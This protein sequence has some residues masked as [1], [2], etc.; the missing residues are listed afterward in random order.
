MNSILEL[1]GHAVAAGASDLFVTAG[2]SP[3]YRIKGELTTDPEKPPVSAGEIDAF[4]RSVIGE[5]GERHYHAASGSDASYAVTE[6]ERYR[7]NFFT[8]L[9]GPGF[10][11]R[12]ILLGGDIHF[13][14]L[15]LPA[16]LPELCSLSRGILL[17]TGSTG[18][19]KST[20]LSAMVNYINTHFHKHILTIEDPIEFMHTDKLSLVTQREIDSSVSGG[21]ARALRFALRENPDVIVIGEMRDMETIQV[22]VT[23]AL[24]GHLVISTVHTTDSIQTVERLIG[25]FPEAQREQLAAD[26][27]LAIQAILSQ[28]LLPRADQKGMVPAVEILLGSG[29]V[30][31]QIADRDF[32]ALEITLKAGV[33]QGMVTFNNA[34][35]QLYREGVITLDTA[36]AASGN[37]AELD[38]M[39]KGMESGNDVFL[40]RY[41]IIADENDEKLV[42]M[43]TLFRTA[44]KTGAS[45]MLLSAGS[46]PMLRLN[47]SMR[48][49]DLPALSPEDVERLLFSVLTK[50]QRIVLEENRELD[51]A[52][53]VTLPVPDG[54]KRKEVRYRFRLNAFYQRGSLGMVARV[55]PTEI[56][57]PEQLHLPGVLVNIVSK[58]QGLI[59]VTGPTGSGKSTTL[60]SLLNLVNRTRPCHIITIEDPIE[61]VYENLQSVVEQRELHSDTL[62]FAPALKAAMR[63]A[64]DVI[65]VGEMRDT[66]TM[67]SAL[68][69]AETGHLV[70]A[71]VHTNSAPQTIDRVIDSFPPNQQ[72]QIRQ[73]LSGTLL[74]V[75]SQRLIPRLN[76]EGRVAAFEV[77]IGTPPAQ[78]LIREGKTHQLQSVIETNFKDGMI[79]LQKSLEALYESG[80]IALEETLRF[81]A[82]CQPTRAY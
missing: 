17:V 74:A 6:T 22:A 71:T 41:G 11:V 59:L 56:P 78:S 34:L 12:P 53:S 14:H 19:G 49:L 55:V 67:A 5:E 7:I 51:F 69:A 46:P 36:L 21:F 63:E 31:K 39:I 48:S 80:E 29:T 3:S 33:N 82:D 32:N 2:K 1:L 47:G 52:L 40:P 13:S 70:L 18:C 76:G 37:P 54:K 60:A 16:I 50:H 27:G 20:T 75:V 8:T 30:K 43:K 58:K 4:R 38:L 68:T 66:E 77:L 62:G 24:T 35:Y 65:M 28:R 81:S 42:D 44:V 57:T 64:P 72:N 9:N 73:Q 26:L 25:L 79:T 61:Y 45:D 15:S 10:V 23:A